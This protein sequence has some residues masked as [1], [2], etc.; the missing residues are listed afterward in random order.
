MCHGTVELETRNGPEAEF[1][2]GTLQV[3][4][5][6]AGTGTYSTGPAMRANLALELRRGGT[7]LG[8]DR[9]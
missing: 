7:E 3:S 6:I 4:S 8:L 9:G 1:W 5:D 2:I